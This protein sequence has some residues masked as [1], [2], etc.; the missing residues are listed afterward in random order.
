VNAAVVVNAVLE[1]GKWREWRVRIR[2][3][4]RREGAKRNYRTHWTRRRRRRPP[5]RETRR[6]LPVP[7][8]HFRPRQIPLLWG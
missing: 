6:H 4:K 8:D 2:L 1:G 7:A 5:R 3:T